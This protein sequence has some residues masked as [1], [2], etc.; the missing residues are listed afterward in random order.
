MVAVED[1]KMIM[2]HVTI[3]NRETSRSLLVKIIKSK[4]IQGVFL[5][6]RLMSLFKVVTEQILYILIT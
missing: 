2:T 3:K 4:I 1:M 5:C 6:D